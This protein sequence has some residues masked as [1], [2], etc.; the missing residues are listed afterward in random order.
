MNSGKYNRIYIIVDTNGYFVSNLLFDFDT[1]REDYH[2]GLI[3]I[4]QKRAD[5]ARKNI[6][7]VIEDRLMNQKFYFNLIPKLKPRYKLSLENYDTSNRLPIS[8]FDRYYY[9][10][11]EI[12]YWD[13]VKIIFYKIISHILQYMRRY[14]IIF[15]VYSVICLGIIIYNF[16]SPPAIVQT[17]NVHYT[18]VDGRA[19]VHIDK[20]NE[21][22]NLREIYYNMPDTHTETK[23]VNVVVPEELRANVIDG[24][25]RV[26]NDINDP[27]IKKEID[28]IVNDSIDDAK[29]NGSI[30]NSLSELSNEEAKYVQPYIDH[31]HYQDHHYST[32]TFQRNVEVP[33]SSNKIIV[34]HKNSK[35]SNIKFIVHPDG[36]GHKMVIVITKFKNGHYPNYDDYYSDDNDNDDSNNNNKSA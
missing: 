34:Q 26:G 8:D 22:I 25:K 16:F 36:N 12:S 11:D 27:R 9:D 30:V 33:N 19:I 15:T 10:Y 3:D 6:L 35:K 31:P 24:E 7:L 4:F 14:I 32:Y 5:Y 18:N 1:D 20:N 21:I 2:I 13:K 28:D 23:E 17:I 29:K